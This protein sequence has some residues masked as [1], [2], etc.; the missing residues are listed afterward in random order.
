[1][2]FRKTNPIS[3]SDSLLCEKRGLEHLARALSGQPLKIPLIHACDRD[4]LQLEHI[5]GDAK[6]STGA[7]RAL[8]GGLAALHRSVGVTFGYE[9]DGYIG[10]NRQLNRPCADWGEFFF[11]MRLTMQVAWIRDHE[12]RK[13]LQAQLL[14]HGQK[15]SRFLN[16]HEPKP[17]LVHGDLWSGNVLFAGECA[18]LIDPAAHYADREVDLAMARLFGGFDEELHSEYDALYPRPARFREREVIYN[19]YHY[20]NHYN[21]FGSAYLGGV[22]Q[23]FQAIERLKC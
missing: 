6:P 12:L 14:I 3:G 1:M 16:A 13:R 22:M 20:V 5:V 19:T 10:L 11:E 21:L 4:L 9:Y 15:V 23:G 7:L 8:A 17:S 2:I 18:Y